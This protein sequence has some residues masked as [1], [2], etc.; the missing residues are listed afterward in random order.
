V[1]PADLGPNPGP[2]SAAQLPRT[3]ASFESSAEIAEYFRVSRE[4]R[5]RLEA[6]ATTLRQWQKAINLVAPSTLPD[7]WRRHIADSAQI[8]DLAPAGI[9]TWADLGSGGG[10]PGLVA[11]ILLAEREPSAR[12]TLIESDQRKAAFLREAARAAGVVVD[13][14]PERIERT[15]TRGSVK[16]VDVISAR[17]L[18]PLSQLFELASPFSAAA[19]VW[20]LPKGRDVGAEVQDAEKAWKF[21]AELVPSLTDPEGRIVVVRNLSPMLAP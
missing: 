4:T 6:Y 1:A 11:A 14:F 9:R 21:D 12:V 10:F 13:I 16:A 2:K 5:T 18:A 7:L 3:P 8:V 17:A 19:T 20:L 15:A